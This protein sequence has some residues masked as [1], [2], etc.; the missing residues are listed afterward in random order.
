[1]ASTTINS[2]NKKYKHI[3]VRLTNSNSLWL[4]EDIPR[5]GPARD[6]VSHNY[7]INQAVELFRENVAAQLQ[8]ARRR[9]KPEEIQ[10]MT[11]ELSKQEVPWRF[12]DYRHMSVTMEQINHYKV[13]R[14]QHWNRAVHIIRQH[15]ST[16][17]EINALLFLSKY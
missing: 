4:N 2:K 9:F 14:C 1:M 16:L 13:D 3:R 15:E 11:V 6:T 12:G 5:F 7:L 17:P 8:A 10:V